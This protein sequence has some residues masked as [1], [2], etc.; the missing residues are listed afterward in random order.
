VRRAVRAVLEAWVSAADVCREMRLQ[1][2]VD[3]ACETEQG[4]RRHAVTSRQK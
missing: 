3:G 4:N 2:E 1:L